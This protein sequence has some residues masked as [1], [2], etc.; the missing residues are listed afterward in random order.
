MILYVVSLTFIL[1]SIFFILN[2]SLEFDG[3]LLKDDVSNIKIIIIDF[4][5]VVLI[6]S[7]VCIVSD[8]KIHKYVLEACDNCSHKISEQYNSKTQ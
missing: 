8:L 7:T 1:T 2:S 5:L 6:I 3:I 4:L